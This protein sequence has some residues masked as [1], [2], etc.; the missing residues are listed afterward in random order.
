MLPPFDIFRIESDGQLIWCASADSLNSAER[1]VKILMA[2][3]AA[4]YLIYSQE[5]G[6]KAI[7]RRK[8]EGIPSPLLPD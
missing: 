6:H 3:T 2:S 5:T 7:V 4:D 8:T 1:R